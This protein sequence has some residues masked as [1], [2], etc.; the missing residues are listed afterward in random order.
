MAAE[1]VA[2]TSW[3]TFEELF[4]VSILGFAIVHYVWRICASLSTCGPS[5]AMS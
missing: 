2:G 3:W 5:Y 4:A 1:M